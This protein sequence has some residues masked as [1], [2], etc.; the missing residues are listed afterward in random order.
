MSEIE[1]S[2]GKV[3]AVAA[4]T[5]ARADEVSELLLNH[6]KRLTILEDSW[7]TSLSIIKWV[8]TSGVVLLAAILVSITHF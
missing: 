6:E 3:L 8:G 2:R 4:R 5:L 1:T 7:T